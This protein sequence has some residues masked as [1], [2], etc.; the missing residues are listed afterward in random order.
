MM[1]EPRRFVATD[2]QEAIKIGELEKTREQRP[3]VK[4]K[5]RAD[6]P[7]AVVKEWIDELTLRRRRRRRRRYVAFVRS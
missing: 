6:I 5:F 7:H 1:E 4:P 3:V 2:Y